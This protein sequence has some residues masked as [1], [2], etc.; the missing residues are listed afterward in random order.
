MFEIKFILFLCNLIRDDCATHKDVID[1]VVLTDLS[2]CR[3]RKRDSENSGL[4]L[5]RHYIY[6]YIYIHVFIARTY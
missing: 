4:S 3:F 1:I 2:D 5:I 6:M